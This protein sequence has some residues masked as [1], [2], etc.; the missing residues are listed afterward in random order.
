M[1][2]ISLATA[3]VFYSSLLGLMAFGI[4][5]YTEITV[6]RAFNV[7]ENQFLWKCVFCGY[8]YLDEEAETLSQCPRCE[9]YN[10]VEDEKARLVKTRVYK[11]ADR[12]TEPSSE[13]TR[14]TSR[15]KRPHQRHRGPRRR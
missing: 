6:R 15:R 14:N 9:S 8:L 10:S 3:L 2:E 4:W 11:T 5:V 13:D 1:I 12:P 7:L